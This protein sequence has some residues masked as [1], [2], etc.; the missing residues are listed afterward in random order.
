MPAP[1]I[2]TPSAKALPSKPRAN[3]PMVGAAYMI[4]AALSFAV[5]NGIMRWAADLG[6]HPFQI[7]FL[8]SAFAALLLIPLIWPTLMSE[9]VGYFK[10]NR[11]W[12][13]LT[14]G[15]AAT[16][17]MI[18]FVTA[19]SQLPLADFTA[20]TFTAPL[21]G[22]I[23]SALIL[24][25]TVKA[26]RW[27]AILIGFAGVL[28]IVRPGMGIM[29]HA[30]LIAIGAAVAM[31]TAGL[32]IKALTRTEPSQKIV[33]ITS[34]ILSV[35]TLIPALFVWH[36]LSP[37]LWGIGFVMGMIGA[38]GHICLTNAFANADASVVLPF[39]YTRLPFAALVGFLAF[40]QVSD[41]I[42]WAGALIVAASA[43]YV[44]HREQKLA[45]R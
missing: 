42:T 3:R 12:L 31:A 44:A 15:L 16:V 30:A 1:E 23:G 33:F 35:T 14:R 8:R 40:G 28:I 4:G 38:I 9:G 24:R 2:E 7:A 29:D 45:T 36:E 25:E 26:R 37:L 13:Y 6:L 39:D 19:V 43:F 20:I 11:P 32:M 10:L 17:G 18:L 34:A 27:T 41:W 22:T 21:F 5:L